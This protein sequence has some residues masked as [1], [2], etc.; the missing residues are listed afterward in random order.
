MITAIDTSVLLDVLFDDP[1]HRAGSLAALR[2]ARRAGT[3]LACPVVR[4]EA[5][6]A[7]PRDGRLHG[8]LR[9]AGVALDPFDEACA[10]TAGRLWAA[11]RSAG[12]RRTRL[13]PDF[14]VGAH[15]LERDAR[16]LTRDRGFY[17]TYFEGLTVVDPSRA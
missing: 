3:V 2:D 17:R 8:L 9:A 6:A 13:I 12:G 15:A 1:V 11:Y 10:R 5:S 7:V 4:A 14:L 16:L